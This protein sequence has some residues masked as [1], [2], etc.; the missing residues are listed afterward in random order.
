MEYKYTNKSFNNTKNIILPDSD[1]IDSFLL[2]NHHNDII[3]AIEFLNSDDKF[4]YIHG[5][6]GTGKRQFI[7]YLCEFLQSDVIM[8]EYY[9]KTSTVCDDILLSFIDYMEK[10]TIAKALVHT[11]K[12]T[13]LA[14]K[15][16][17]YISSIKKPF[18]IILHSYDDIAEE[19]L[20]NVSDTMAKIIKNDNVKIIVSTRAMLQEVFQDIKVDKK[21][22][23]KP[24][25]K[26]MFKSF[27]KSYNVDGTEDAYD[28]FYKYSR[29]YYYYTVLSIKIIK[30]MEISINDFLAKYTMSGMSFDNFLGFTYIN[31]IPGA[32]RNF[33]WFLRTLRHG[34]SLN[35]LAVL[36]LYDDFAIEYLKNN[37]MIYIA[38]DI[39][40]VQDY[41]QQD[42]DISIPVKT[43]VKLHKY[44]KEIYEKDLKESLQT[45]SILISRQALRAEIEYHN[46]KI[47]ELENNQKK[48]QIIAQEAVKPKKNKK[49]EISNDEETADLSQK[50]KK[51]GKLAENKQ[52]TDAT[53]AYINIIENEKLDDN[54]LAELRVELGRLYKAVG[55]YQHAQHYYELAEKYYKSKNE[56]INLNYLYYELTNLYF[57]MY[58]MDRAIETIKKV[59]YSVD[60]PQSLMVD[61]CTL[62]GNIYSEIKNYDEASKYY[63]KALES[64]DENTSP[65]GLAELYF[66]YALMCDENDDDSTAFEYYSKCIYLNDTNSYKALSY[67]NMGSCYF[68]NDNY[69]DAE[70]CF[71][72]AYNIEKN[73]NNYE[74]IYYTA[75]YLAKIYMKSNSQKALK[76]LT[77]AKQ[78]AE[79][80][81]ED[82]YILEATIALGDY[83]YN[84]K[85]TN[86]EALTEYFKALKISKNYGTTVDIEKIQERISDMKIRV[87]KEDFEKLEKKYG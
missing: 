28:D 83:Y 48:E 44:I 26:E 85:A 38:Q 7:N 62:L 45:R 53:E 73:N 4:L 66:K 77:E 71:S 8:L 65:E 60:T 84:N 10:S 6:L 51:A 24:F 72:K 36:G 25:P 13:T 20:Q 52:Y 19:N 14:V 35:A 81:N 78:S 18:I 31:L 46:R 74:G 17:Q 5:F 33:F 50:I 82:F 75:S 87:D 1:R 22:F 9:C 30:A 80:L 59:I 15:F 42:I 40:Y 70:A 56:Y 23:L 67:S 76:F 49:A 34:I 27:V 64:I 61:S 3:K 43:E 58:K 11:A 54:T 68:E 69:S 39:V 86:K 29:G 47:T 57:E 55:D 32:I 16:Q 2:Q 63:Q 12:V 79:F 21:L 37:L 41:F